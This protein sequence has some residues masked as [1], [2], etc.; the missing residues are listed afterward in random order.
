VNASNIQ[1]SAGLHEMPVKT[2]PSSERGAASDHREPD[3]GAVPAVSWGR[4]VV[5]G[6]RRLGF[7]RHR[8]ALQLGKRP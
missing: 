4:L 3:W 6:G 8:G 2:A 7:G 1:R 5:A